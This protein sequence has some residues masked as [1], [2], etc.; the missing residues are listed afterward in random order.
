M[1]DVRLGGLYVDL[2]GRNSQFLRSASQSAAALRRQQQSVRAFQRQLRSFNTRIRSAVRS[3]FNFRTALVALGGGGAL[4]ALVRS[5]AEFG[6]SVLQVSERLGFTVER[7]QLLRA[8]FESVGVPQAAVDIGLQRF[9]RRLADAAQGNALLLQT[10]TQLGVSITGAGGSLRDTNEVLLDVAEGLSGIDDQAERVRLAFTLFDTEGVR[11]VN[12][13][14][15]GREGFEGVRFVNALQ[16][17]REGFDDDLVTSFERFGTLS[18]D[19]VDSLNRLNIGFQQTA[20]AIRVALAGAVADASEE[21]SV[22]N[23]RVAE[24]AASFGAGLGN[25]IQNTG[26]ELRPGRT[27][28]AVVHR[29]VGGQ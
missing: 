17:G 14:Q 10:F 24:A 29:R 2:R 27:G 3:V 28:R 4:G 21:L 8:A 11:F 23:T 6:A 25:A 13:L 9:S 18:E 12:A 5:Q 20:T 7:L 19:Q 16:E 1:A 22:L 15:E 26:G